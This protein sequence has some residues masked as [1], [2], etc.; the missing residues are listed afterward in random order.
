MKTRSG[1]SSDGS[2]PDSTSLVFGY[3]AERAQRWLEE[4]LK[5]TRASLARKAGLRPDQ[6]HEIL[7]GERRPT[8]R[9]MRA[10]A[11]ALGLD[12][13]DLE[14]SAA[15]WVQSAQTFAAAGST[16]SRAARGASDKLVRVVE[17]PSERYPNRAKAVEAAAL[18]E[19]DPRDVETVLAIVLPPGTTDPTPRAWMSWIERAREERLGASGPV[20]RSR[21][22]RTPRE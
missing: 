9:S 18:L 12:F 1:S 7:N 16:G 5:R 19:H 20:R 10:V 15:Q 3:V 6:I 21:P 14:Q 13:E 4:D 11:R 8:V 22:R 2:S 17:E